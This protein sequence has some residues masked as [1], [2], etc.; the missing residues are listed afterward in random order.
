MLLTLTTSHAPA[1]DLGYLLHKH[2]DRWQRFDLSFGEAT[3]FYPEASV[4]RCTAALRVEVD[5]VGLVRRAPGAEA[6]ALGQYVNDRPYAASSL[7]SVAIARVFDSALNGKCKDRPELVS[8]SLPL[9]ATVAALP[10]RGGEKLLR[11]LFEPLGYALEIARRPLDPR[12]PDW[13]GSPYHDLTLRATLP[14]QRLLGHLYVLIPVLDD[15]KHYWVGEDEVE[16]LLKAGAGWLA[17]HP[18]R[19][20]I[21]RRYLKH[22]RGL[23]RGALARLTEDQPEETA[24]VESRPADRQEAELEKPL[25]LN[26]QRLEQVIATLAELGAASVADLGC[27][28]GKLLRGLLAEKRFARIFGMDVSPRALKIAAD[29]LDLERLPDA[30]RA[31][32]T[33]AQGSLLY[34]DA[35]LAGFDAAALVEVIEHLDA[36]RLQACE[37][38]VFE[39][40]RPGSV[41]V[42]TPNREYNALFP[43]LPAGKFRHSDHRFEWTRAE[44][45]AWAERVAARHGYAVEYRPV[46]P[47]DPAL[48]APTQMGV[49]R[50]G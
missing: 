4:E 20:L 17:V 15:Q 12:F 5:P 29:R 14:L 47:V 33:L 1:T 16:K 24:A 13:G 10:C 45:A 23:V 49:F 32:L 21:T 39:C 38:V 2:P 28:E 30:Q 9:E 44:F 46:G 31:R 37:R 18:A 34:R 42:T 6:F 40:A 3:I 35:R 7:L 22:R 26:G 19:E 36:P 25:S 41:V 8:A 43:T 27:G 11:E 50:R 48:G